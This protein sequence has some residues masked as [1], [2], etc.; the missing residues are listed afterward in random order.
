VLIPTPR[1]TASTAWGHSALPTSSKEAL[2]PRIIHAQL[3]G[4]WSSTMVRTNERPDEENTFIEP[5][6]ITAG[7]DLSHRS[8]GPTPTRLTR[9]FAL[10][11][12]AGALSGSR[13]PVA[14]KKGPTS[15]DI[16]PSRLLPAA[17][18]SPTQFP[19]Q[20]HRR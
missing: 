15:F 19:V 16:G 7:S 3:W 14:K 1:A 5:L 20:Y 10:A 8:W 9:A 18:Y 17:T 6:L 13:S 2:P 11:R 4:Q 12:A